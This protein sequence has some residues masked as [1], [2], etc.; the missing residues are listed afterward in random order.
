MNFLEKKTMKTIILM[1]VLGLALILTACTGVDTTIHLYPVTFMSHDNEP[2]GTQYIERGRTVDRP[3]A[4]P[5]RKH[6]TFVN[7]FTQETGGEL[8]NF[9]TPI[10]ESTTV[11]ARWAQYPRTITFMLQGGSWAADNTKL[12]EHGHPVARPLADPTRSGYFFD[13]WYD[14]A[15]GGVPWDFLEPIKDDIILWARWSAAVR[16]TFHLA[17]GNLDYHT[18]F[19]RRKGSTIADIPLPT[20]SGS[21][22][23][24]GLFRVPANGWD[25]WPFT[26]WQSEGN[27]WTVTDPILENINLTAKWAYGPM[28]I[29]DV[30]PPP[31]STT[32]FIQRAF[33]YANENPGDYY[34]LLNEDISL[35]TFPMRSTGFTIPLSLGGTLMAGDILRNSSVTLIGLGEMRTITRTATTG[36]LFMATDTASLIVGQNI[37]LS[38]NSEYPANAG[39]LLIYGQDASAYM[40]AGSRITNHRQTV[41]NAGFNAPVLVRNAAFT[42]KGGEII[43]NS[44]VP[45]SGVDNSGAVRVCHGGTFNMKAGRIFANTVTMT[46]GGQAGGVFVTG[47]G[48]T[49]N[50]FGGEISG[51]TVVGGNATAGGVRVTASAVFNMNGGIIL[52]NLNTTNVSW[53]SGGVVVWGATSTFNMNGGVISGNTATGSSS[54]GGVY[55]STGTFNMNGGQISGNTANGNLSGGG[56]RIHT[57]AHFA[58]RGGLIFGNTANGIDSGG[59]V[60]AD[61]GAAGSVRISGGTIFGDEPSTPELLRNTATFAGADPGLGAALRSVSGVV[62]YGLWD[63]GGNWHSFGQFSVGTRAQATAGTHGAYHDTI[64]VINGV[65]Q[66]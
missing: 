26:G 64:R 47:V 10:T 50:M 13:G 19:Y 16:I 44:S 53:T 22:A 27:M 45:N 65:L 51:N 11:W 14:E 61:F 34:L 30:L 63:L 23:V 59:G 15:Y 18:R 37:T 5:E 57:S 42:M 12:T 55:L 9:D 21:P 25:N 66:N 54:A 46:S 56:L 60:R 2:L 58:M 32:N 36:V 28:P 39:L 8:F 49:F 62:H 29:P 20:K 35:P 1:I 41:T 4:D 7:W 48:S 6:W 17:G 38:G 43:G 52:N 3:F 24:Q 31:F 33:Y 40:L